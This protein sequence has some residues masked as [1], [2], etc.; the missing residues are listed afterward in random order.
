VLLIVSANFIPDGNY[1]ARI[2]KCTNKVVDANASS[3]CQV[4]RVFAVT[5]GSGTD[6]YLL[7]GINNGN[8]GSAIFRYYINT[9]GNTTE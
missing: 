3:T 9:D 4:E 8:G 5:K 2:S 7:L 6:Q 1:N